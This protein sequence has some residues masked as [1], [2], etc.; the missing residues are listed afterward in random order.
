MLNHLPAE[1]LSAAPWGLEEGEVTGYLVMTVEESSGET[2]VSNR[3]REVEGMFQVW[4]YGQ[5]GD[6]Q[7]TNTEDRVKEIR[8][9]DCPDKERRDLLGLTLSSLDYPHWI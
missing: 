4:P 9:V 7:E 8:G 5:D 2:R 1:S 6:L 3:L